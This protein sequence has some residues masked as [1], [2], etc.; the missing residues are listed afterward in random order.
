MELYK[1]S[2]SLNSNA[3]YSDFSDMVNFWNKVS[4]GDNTMEDLQQPTTLK[5]AYELLQTVK[6]T[7]IK[8]KSLIESETSN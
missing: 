2:D 5:S 1:K 4:N 6:N 7:G 3:K 8:L